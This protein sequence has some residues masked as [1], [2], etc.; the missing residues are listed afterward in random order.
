MLH[1]ARICARCKEWNCWDILLGQSFFRN[2]REVTF[3]E[4]EGE[5]EL[6]P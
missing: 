3:R 6:R 2:Y 4:A 5:V 1:M